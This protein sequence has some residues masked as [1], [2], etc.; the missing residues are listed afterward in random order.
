MPAAAAPV[1]VGLAVA[2]GLAEAV[3]DAVGSVLPL[4]QSSGEPTF[5]H[6]VGYGAVE[7]RTS[8]P[9][10]KVGLLQLP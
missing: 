1:A 6:L 2:P 9:L 8:L 5:W 4:L 10:M 7:S 3:L